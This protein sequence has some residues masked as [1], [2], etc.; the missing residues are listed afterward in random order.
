MVIINCRYSASVPP[1]HIYDSQWHNS[2]LISASCPPSPGPGCNTHLPREL[3]GLPSTVSLLIHCPLEGHSFA[4]CS[5]PCLKW[6]LSNV[7]ARPCLMPAQRLAVPDSSSPVWMVLRAQLDF[8]WGTSGRKY[9]DFLA[10]LHQ[11]WLWAQLWVLAY[12][13]ISKKSGYGSHIN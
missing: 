12:H 1:F 6:S 13:E 3:Y 9:K 2:R 7:S 4:P 10:V 8:S 5:C 11:W